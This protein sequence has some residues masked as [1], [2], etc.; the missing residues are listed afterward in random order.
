MKR[1]RVSQTCQLDP[2]PLSQDD[3]NS[4][5]A[6]LESFLKDFKASPEQTIAHALGNITIDEDDFS[7]DDELMEDDGARQT[8]RR[9][10]TP[11]AHKYQAMMQKLA[12]RQ[13]DEVLVDLDDIAAVGKPE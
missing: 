13:I 3:P 5:L 12:D 6:A 8:R 9:D 1:S 10:K 7:D 11:P 2:T 4:L